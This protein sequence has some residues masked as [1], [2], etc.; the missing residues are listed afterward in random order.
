MIDRV[1]P[2]DCNV[3]PKTFEIMSK[4]KQFE[5]DI[6]KMRATIISIVMRPPGLMNKGAHKFIKQIPVSTEKTKKIRTAHILRR[7]LSL[8]IIFSFEKDQFTRHLK[9]QL[10]SFCLVS[11]AYLLSQ[12]FKIKQQ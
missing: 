12:A 10:P 7:D 5:I 8:Y 11:W 1:A 2:T 6:Q 9:F 4:F 3:P